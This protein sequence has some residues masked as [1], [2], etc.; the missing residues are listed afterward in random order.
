M[1]HLMNTYARLPVA[2][3]H[4]KGA[5]LYDTQ[6]QEYLDALAGIAVNG[7]GHAHPRLTAALAEQVGRLIHTS[8]IYQV[9]E[10]DALAEIGSIVINACTG[11]LAGSFGWDVEASVPNV[12]VSSRDRPFCDGESLSSALVTHLRMHLSGLRVEGLVLLE[13]SGID[14]PTLPGQRRLHA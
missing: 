14:G 5:W 10:Q 1:S 6:G 13:L 4:G 7:L 12:T 3:T 8:N 11:A 2:F 9:T